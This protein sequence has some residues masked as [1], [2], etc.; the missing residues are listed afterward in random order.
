[1]GGTHGGGWFAATHA[2]VYGQAHLID[3]DTPG[4]LIW[5]ATALA[6]WNGLHVPNG[7][8]GGSRSESCSLLRGIRGDLKNLESCA[9]NRPRA[10]GS[11]PL[12]TVDGMVRRPAVYELHGE[13]GTPP[14]KVLDLAGGVLPAAALRHIEVQRLEAH[15]K[16]TMLDIN[17][18]NTSDPQAVRRQLSEFAVRD[19]DEI[20]IFPI[21]PYNTDE[22]YL[23]GHVL[24]PG[25]YACTPGMHIP[26]LTSPLTETF[27]RSRPGTM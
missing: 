17:L 22:V 7:R 18:D 8:A 3:T 13:L 4:L 11:G 19:G 14:A 23:Q 12:V 9:R 2:R 24:R 1:M 15:E 25:R 27:F 26:D 10:P 5:S 16:R 6:F 20:H 21:A